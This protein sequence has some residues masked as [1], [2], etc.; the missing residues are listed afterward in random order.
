M[1]TLSMK[2]LQQ[3]FTLIELMIVVAIIGILAAIAIPAYQDYTVRTQVA[4]GLTL[5][6]QAK[7]AI[8]ESFTNNGQAPA[9]RALAGMSANATDTQGNFVSQLGVAN[10]VITVTY[11]N[12]AP[13]RANVVINN[14][15]ITLVPYV[16]VD[17][18]ISWKCRAV[19]SVAVPGPGV[20]MGTG[21]ATVAVNAVG[22]VPARFA[23]AE[24]RA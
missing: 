18:S 2:K 7:T 8:S 15:T 3:G 20:L 10:G 13:Q 5:A 17:G 16:S 4:E 19:G 22:T 21:S 1:N 12:V 14:L 24:C 6:A 9:T 23:P 11:S